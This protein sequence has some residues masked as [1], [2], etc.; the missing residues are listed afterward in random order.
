MVDTHLTTVKITLVKAHP[1]CSLSLLS[2]YPISVMLVATVLAVSSWNYGN[3]DKESLD[4][5]MSTDVTSL[6]PW[7]KVQQFNIF[8][9]I[10]ISLILSIN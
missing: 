3:T 4:N 10:L 6:T 5:A 7:I 9:L 8:Y 2:L 1:A